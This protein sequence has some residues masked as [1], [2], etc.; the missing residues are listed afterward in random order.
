MKFFCPRCGQKL[1]CEE[2]EQGTTVSCPSC[3]NAI[4]VPAL[5]PQANT[6]TVKPVE[7]KE[8]SVKSEGPSPYDE[9]EYVIM[10]GGTHWGFYSHDLFF[11][12]VFFVLAYFYRD[13]APL[14]VM[15]GL[16][17]VI[18][19]AFQMSKHRWVLTNKRLT[20]TNGIVVKQEDQVRVT[21]IRGIA[22]RRDFVDTSWEMGS[23]AVGSAASS[24]YEIILFHIHK[25]DILV[26]KIE[27]LRKKVK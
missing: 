17:F 27:E 15:A 19:F 13:Y 10:Q 24:D 4:T 23:V 1:S 3:S 18:I 14:H 9:K 2:D 22:I 8:E 12:G 7:T 25:P 26:E 6:N 21:D 20:V 16:I 5:I 11:A